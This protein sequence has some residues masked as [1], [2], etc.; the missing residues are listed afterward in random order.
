MLSVPM[1]FGP[2][3]VVYFSFSFSLDCMVFLLCGSAAIENDL[4]LWLVL[5]TSCGVGFVVALLEVCARPQNL[6]LPYRYLS[7]LFSI[8]NS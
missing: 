1:D 7:L 8:L 2:V 4:F 5:M 3:K 6:D